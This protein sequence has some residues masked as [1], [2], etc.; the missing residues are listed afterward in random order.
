MSL[1]DIVTSYIDK[2]MPHLPE[3]NEART[4]VSAAQAE[5]NELYKKYKIP[6]EEYSVFDLPDELHQEPYEYDG[7]YFDYDAL[8]ENLADEGVDR[9]EIE[10]LC[11]DMTNICGTTTI[12]WEASRC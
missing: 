4:K 2:K 7:H 3:V 11:K 9:L 8:Y 6:S 1:K 5:L 10:K 12:V